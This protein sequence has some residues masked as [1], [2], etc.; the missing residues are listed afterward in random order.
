MPG[1]PGVDLKRDLEQFKILFENPNLKPDSL[2]IYPTVVIKGTKLYEMWKQGDYKP[3]TNTETVKLLAKAQKFIPKYC[4]IVRMQRDISAKKIEAGPWKSNLRELLE[5]TAEKRRI[6]IN[7]IRYREVG[8]KIL[9]GAEVNLENIKLCRLD[10]DASN[11]KEIFLSFEDV[12][13]DILIGF[14]RLRIPF[15]PFRQEI[16]EKTALVRELHVYG[17]LVSIGQ[18]PTEEWQHR[19]FGRELLQEAEKIA[20]EEFDKNKMVIISGIGA[21]LYF[22]KQD[23]KHDG[24]YVS[25]NLS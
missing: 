17:P 19:G 14:I 20:E 10:Y 8:H 23:Y 4:R 24:V 18:Q 25:K 12:K 11:G 13:N 1:L 7:E 9:K 5:S 21:K 16:T 22:L 15:K 2:K 6:K 3:L